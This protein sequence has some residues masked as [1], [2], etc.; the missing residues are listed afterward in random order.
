MK[1]QH[2][3][4][5]GTAPLIAAA[6]CLGAPATITY[7]PAGYAG[8]DLSADGSVVAGNVIFDFSYETFRWTAT[9]GAVRLGRATVPVIGVGAGTP[10]ISYD[11][12][13]ISATIIDETNTLATQGLWNNGTWI[14]AL[15]PTGPDGATLDA[16]YGSSWGLSGDG[17]HMTGFYWT[18]EANAHPSTWSIAGGLTPLDV[19]DDRSARV[20]GANYDGSVVVGWEER[21]DGAW[22]PTVWRNGVKMITNATEYFTECEQ[23]SGDGLKVVGDTF[24]PNSA[25]VEAAVW[26]W[27]GVDYD[28]QLLGTLHGTVVGAGRSGATGISD[29]GSIVV[30]FNVY[31]FAPYDT[32]DGWISVNGGAMVEASVF[33]ASI[34]IV[35]PPELDIFDFYTVSADGSTILGDAF[36]TSTIQYQTFLVTLPTSCPSDA[37]CPP[38]LNGDGAV[39]TADLGLLITAFGTSEECSDINGDGVVDTADLGI[40]ISAFGTGC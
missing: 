4:L 19:E 37:T 16:S 14:E 38:D 9:G 39:D 33:L 28:Q 36:N 12:T 22:Q 27:N 17:E 10:D 18:T 40:L 31:S 26:T 35:L 13:R 15:P 2:R 3:L 34:G 25:T 32:G 5:A 7:L 11:G 24:N 1:P 23:V 6:V 20:N 21:P 29:D 30:G 8:S